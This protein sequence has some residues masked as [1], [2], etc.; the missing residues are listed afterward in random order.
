MFQ[1]WRATRATDRAF[2][3]AY[4]RTVDDCLAVLFCGFPAGLLPAIRHRIGNSLIRRAQA[5]GTSARTCAVQVAVLL[6]RKILGGLSSQQRQDLARAFLEKDTAHPVYKGFKSMFW[7]MEELKVPPALVTYLDAEVA[8]QLRGMPQQA[9]F[10]SWV[11]GQIGGVMG[12]MRER[13]QEE[14]EF[15]AELWQ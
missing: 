7:V 8:G 6:I 9:I 3:R 12:R 5:E 11:E 2:K 4:R 10:G 14:A 13:C 15:K 1:A